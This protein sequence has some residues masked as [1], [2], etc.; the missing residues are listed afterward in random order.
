MPEVELGALPKV[1]AIVSLSRSEIYRRVRARTFPAPV[2]LGT[3]CSRWSLTEVREWV[4][5]RLAERRVQEITVT[6]EPS[7][8]KAAA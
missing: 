8:K 4:A 2:S 5:A 7:A 6:V 1:R 3:R